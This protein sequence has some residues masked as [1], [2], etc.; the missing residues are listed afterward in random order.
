[1]KL[2][3]DQQEA[4][5]DATSPDFLQKGDLAFREEN[6]YWPW[7]SK[8]GGIWAFPTTASMRGKEKVAIRRDFELTDSQYEKLVEETNK[9]STNINLFWAQI[10]KERG[11]KWW[12]V[13]RTGR[14]F[15]CSK[16]F[17]AEIL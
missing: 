2:T 17:T 9:G 16:I 5:A 13:A 7:Q 1:M 10:G 14:K 8:R 6:G 4:A 15:D 11:F 3:P 12:T